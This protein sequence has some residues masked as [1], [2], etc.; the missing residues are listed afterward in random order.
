MLGSCTGELGS[1]IGGSCVG[2]CVEGLNWA[3]EQLYWEVVL[4]VVLKS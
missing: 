3:V 1:C 4:G 2:S